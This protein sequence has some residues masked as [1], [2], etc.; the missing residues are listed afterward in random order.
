MKTVK[1]YETDPHLISFS[2]R[3]L[4][5]EEG[6]GGYEVVLDQT[7]F[8]PEGGGQ[9]ADEGS[10]GEALVLHVKE[11]EGRI[12]HI[13]S[14]PLT[15]GDM[16]EG[17]ILWEK[18]FPRMQNHAAEHILS[19]LAHA[20]Y[21]CNNVGFHLGD[22]FFTVDFDL[23]LTPAEIGALQEEANRVIWENQPI[24]AWVPTP[25]EL[26]SLEYRA[27]LE[28]SE[29]VRLVKIGGADLCACCAPH[30]AATGEI[31]LVK[32]MDA[33]SYKGGT[34][35]T[36]FAGVW[37]MAD[38][39]ALCGETR[40][41]MHLY[42]AKRGEVLPAAVREH[43]E[44]QALR[45][46]ISS[47]KEKLALAQLET[48]P[49][50]GGVVAFLPEGGFDE[51]RA[52]ANAL[53]EQGFDKRLLFAPQGEGNFIWVAAAVKGDTRPVVK[54]L[55]EAFS[56]KGG[57]KPTWAQ[58]KLTASDPATLLATAKKMLSLSSY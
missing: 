1:L 52:A 44:L 42:S 7:A 2:A 26:S 39:T 37:A 30:P 18:R 29:G 22:G 34:R 40:S 17:K 47:L 33:V 16:V 14:A 36:A 12:S 10:L 4:S 9:A 46:E 57:G 21:G 54:A 28:L 3:V 20:K 38:Y 24:S 31:G 5:C 8:F 15:V 43:E 48:H 27:K 25:E 32:V 45:Y 55:A 11:K 56:A 6:K 51:M 23:P 19:G 49:V 53:A 35:L 41:L 58:G 50:E 13:V